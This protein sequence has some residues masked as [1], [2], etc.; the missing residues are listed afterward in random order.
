MLTIGISGGLD[1]VNQYREILFPRGFF[2][3]AAA[4]L[5][6]DGRVLAGIEEE[7]LNRIK[8]TSKGPVNSIRFCL[9]SQGLKLDNIDSLV[10]YGSEEMCDGVLRNLFYGS[11]EAQPVATMREL[12]HQFLQQGVGQDLD[13]SKLV[14][15][16]HHLAHAISAYAQSGFPE[17]LVFT[18]DGAGDALCGSVS[19]WNG[20]QY[21]LLHSFPMAQSLG[22]FYDR[23]IAMLGY[24]FTE[25]YKVMGLAPYGNSAKYQHVF[26][27]LFDLLPQGNYVLHWHHIEDLYEL[28]PARKKGEPILQEHID[29][30]A[31]LQ[32]SLESIVMHI[33]E[34][35]RS[36]TGLKSMCFAGGVAHNSTLNGK[37]LYSGMFDEVFVQPASHDGG[38]ALGAALYPHILPN[39]DGPTN[40]STVS[41][42]RVDEVYWGTDIGDNDEILATL[43]EWHELVDFECLENLAV[44]TAELLAGGKVVGWVQ[45]R[46]EF[47]PRALGNRSILADPRPPENKQLINQMIKK[48]EAYRPFAPAVLEEN[49][50]EY[51]EIPIKDMRFPFMSFT[52]KVK[53]DKRALLGATTH[54]DGTARTQ[55]VSRNNP[56]FWDLIEA[57]GKITGVDVLLNTSFNNNVEPIVDSADDA[58]ACFLTTDLHHLVVGD[59]LVSKKSPGAQLVLNLSASLPPYSR[60]LKVKSLGD[61][62]EV[63]LRHEIT[64]SY[65][66]DLLPISEAIFNVLF[67][68]SPEQ[69]LSELI[70]NQAPEV[71]RDELANEM[72]KLWQERAIKLRPPVRVGQ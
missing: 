72:L 61:A 68:S 23:V 44:R 7:R 5:V 67:N 15:V 70:E 53:P 49:A 25:E 59:F 3:D 12:L 64:N 69:K 65:N 55:T 32:A 43:N 45:G 41:F 19:H 16:N 21:K 20:P 22:V 17:S 13:D 52:L 10:F 35:Y 63:V 9:E 1:L 11:S 51:F 8:H 2:H 34:Y 42:K 31:G 30:A 14:F 39:G 66:D 60:L 4:V 54:V 40:G 57:F 27:R 46:S 48:R 28:A 37:I 71:D 18:I 50:D 6:E 56:R 33:V 58:L 26:D 62:G 36:L 47:G 24:G 38:A 29:I